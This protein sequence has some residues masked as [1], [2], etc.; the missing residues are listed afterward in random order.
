MYIREVIERFSTLFCSYLSP[1]TLGRTHRKSSISATGRDE[2]GWLDPQHVNLD[3]FYEARPPWKMKCSCCEKKHWS[4]THVITLTP[5]RGSAG[6]HPQAMAPM[7]PLCLKHQKP[8]MSK[9][10]L[11]SSQVLLPWP[12]SVSPSSGLPRM[13]TFDIFKTGTQILSTKTLSQTIN[14]GSRWSYQSNCSKTLLL[15]SLWTTW[16]IPQPLI[17]VNK[18]QILKCLERYFHSANSLHTFN[19]QILIHI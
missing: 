6:I 17:H 7:C 5:T 10:I 8:P 1:L 4:N 16:T 9:A 15:C 2:G 19:L 3:L 14:R 13:V 11:V 18:Y 12:L